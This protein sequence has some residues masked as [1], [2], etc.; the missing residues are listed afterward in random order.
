MMKL[1][2][3]LQKAKI[4]HTLLCGAQLVST[5]KESLTIVTSM[6]NNK[7]GSFQYNFHRGQLGLFEIGQKQIKF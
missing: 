3:P 6:L 4:E 1:D 7:S 5:S 2:V